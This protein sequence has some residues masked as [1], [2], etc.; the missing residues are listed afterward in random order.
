M[1]VEVKYGSQISILKLTVVEG[2]E[3]S[4]FGRDWLGQLRLDWK[5]IGLAMLSD[6]NTQIKVL[7]KKYDQVFSA[8][9]GTK[10]HCKAS[11]NV[12]P[13]VKLIFFRPRSIPFAITETVEKELN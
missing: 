7:Q 13:A 2:S 4:L 3:P 5:T 9:L 11:L 8:G 12:K 1:N 6:H 10:L